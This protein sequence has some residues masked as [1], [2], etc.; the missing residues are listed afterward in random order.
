MPLLKDGRLVE[1]P[2]RAVDDVAPLPVDAPLIVSLAR[3]QAERQALLERWAP[4][5]VRLRNSD[6]IEA[7]TGVVNRFA[8]IALEFPRFSDGRAYS[9]ARGL[10]ERMGFAGELRATGDV[11]V[12][13]ALFMR[14]CGFSAYEVA[15]A[16]LAPRFVEAFS[17]FSVF[18]QPAGDGI[19]PVATLRRFASAA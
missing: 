3:F 13:Q 4:L 1:D 19:A 5:G 14:R 7:L 11:L 9:Q 16:A 17:S 18:Y 12:D 6:A 15:D 2:W 10:R 8:L